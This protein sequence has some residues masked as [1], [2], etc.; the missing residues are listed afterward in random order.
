MI[1]GYESD[2]AGIDRRRSR[3]FRTQIYAEIY[4]QTPIPAIIFG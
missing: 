3:L 4:E 2:N 1:F